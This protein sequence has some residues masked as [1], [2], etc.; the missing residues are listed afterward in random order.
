LSPLSAE[1]ARTIIGTESKLP[2]ITCGE[3]SEGSRESM[4]LIA[5]LSR[6]VASEVVVPNSKETL[7]TERP[8]EEVT[9]VDS[10]PWSPMTA[11]SI[12][13]ETCWSTTSGD[14]PG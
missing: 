5:L 2:E 6:S 9:V 11:F 10:R 4:V 1:I 3:T 14:A 8:V 13:T 12:T 7:S